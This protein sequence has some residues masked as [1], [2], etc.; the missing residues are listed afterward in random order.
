MVVSGCGGAK[1][2]KV[3]G[4]VTLGGQPLSG[5]MV[6]FQPKAGSSPSAGRTD[7]S[8][9]YSLVFTRKINGAEIGEHD[10]TISTY[11]EGDPG[12]EP[13]VPQVAEQVPL[14]YRNRGGLTATVKSGSNVIDFPLEPGPIEEP[15]PEKGKAKK[16]P[17][18]CF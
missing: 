9:A 5:A 2:A 8:G 15:K 10:V 12:G 4:K 11:Q 1:V 7:G 17:D 16:N 3:T 6:I 13:P 14:K 18:G